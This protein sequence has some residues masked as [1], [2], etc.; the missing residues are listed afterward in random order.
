MYNNNTKYA[1]RAYSVSATVL[2]TYIYLF[3]LHNNLIIKKLLTVPFFSLLFSRS[4]VSNSLQSHGLQLTR[5]PCPSLSPRV[6]SNSCPLSWWCH[7]IISLSIIPFSSCPQSFP[8]SGTSPVS[9]LFISVA[10]YWSFGFSNSPS[11][12]F[13]GLISLRIDWFDLLAVQETLKSLL[14]H[15]SSKA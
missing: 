13:S 6:C 14:Q 3:A 5:P 1:H 8:A 9:Q 15:H 12:E 4:V 10:K 7:P 2:I 11:N